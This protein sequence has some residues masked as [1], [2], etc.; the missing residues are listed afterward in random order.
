MKPETVVKQNPDLIAT[1]IDGDL[2]L[3]H[4]DTGEYYG[5]KLTGHHIWQLMENPCAIE[6]IVDELVKHYDADRE[7]IATDVSAFLTDL[8]AAG[9]I[10]VED[11]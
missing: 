3:L 11:D 6:N 7:T 9:L 8:H 2:V 1:T 5:A 10:L 4:P